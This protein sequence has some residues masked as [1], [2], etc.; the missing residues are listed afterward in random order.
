MKRRRCETRGDISGPCDVTDEGERGRK[1]LHAAKAGAFNGEASPVWEANKNGGA[2]MGGGG[3]AMRGEPCRTRAKARR[4]GEKERGGKGGQASL[5]RGAWGND[6][7]G[8]LR[9]LLLVVSVLPQLGSSLS[10][11]LRRRRRQSL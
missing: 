4:G 1:Q 5:V 7:L 10:L 6:A 9:Q 11:L 8:P 2:G 3:Y